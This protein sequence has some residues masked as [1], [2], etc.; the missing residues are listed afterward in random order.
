MG[1]NHPLELI[2]CAVGWRS[3]LALCEKFAAHQNGT[4]LI[5]R[6]CLQLE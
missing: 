3:L 1:E 4:L 6:D 5:G 2:F